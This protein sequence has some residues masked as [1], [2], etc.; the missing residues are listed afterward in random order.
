MAFTLPKLPYDLSALAPVLSKETF[1][2]HYGK[3]H[4]AYIDNMNKALEDSP[5]KGSSLEEIVRKSSGPMFNNSAQAWNHTFYWFCFT[6]NG[7]NHMSLKLEEA[8]NATWGSKDKF[9]ETF[10]AQAV[11]NFGSGWT[12]LVKDKAG[13]LSLVN[14]SNAETPITKDLIPLFVADVW[15]HAYYIDYRNARKG[16]LDA[17]PKIINWKFVSECFQANE[18]FDC[19]KVM[20]A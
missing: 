12:W 3:H 15:E 13:K 16:Y 17:L 4:K 2:F 9:W 7:D 18:V 19:T 10:T 11:G 14:T 1:D 6:P 5:L 20:K 8:I